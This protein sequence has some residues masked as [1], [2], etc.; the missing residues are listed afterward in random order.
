MFLASLFRVICHTQF[1]VTPLW[2]LTFPIPEQLLFHRQIR[3]HKQ[4]YIVI[5]QEQLCV[6]LLLYVQA[7]WKNSPII[8]QRG[9]LIWEQLYFGNGLRPLSLCSGWVW[10][11]VLSSATF[12]VS[13]L[14]FFLNRSIAHSPFLLFWVLNTSTVAPTRCLW[15]FGRW[16]VPLPF[17]R[18]SFSAS[19]FAATNKVRNIF[20]GTA[21]GSYRPTWFP[22]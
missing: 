11:V 15:D 20:G 4:N 21:R 16:V 5:M 3:H 10:S 8:N 18:P 12:F 6:C 17:P 19:L 7:V 22:S 2:F 14:G 13:C 9:F 1:G